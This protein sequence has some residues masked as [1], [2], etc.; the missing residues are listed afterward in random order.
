MQQPQTSRDHANNRARRHHWRD[1]LGCQSTP[2]V[3]DSGPARN[4]P[5]V[6]SMR[7]T[8]PR[9]GSDADKDPEQAARVARDV[10]HALGTR[11]LASVVIL[12]KLRQLF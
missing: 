11:G 7:N 3:L 4:L 2:A 10:E 8:A 9:A 1:G 12:P 5:H 6:S